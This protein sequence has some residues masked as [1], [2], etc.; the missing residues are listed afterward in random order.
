[1]ERD[2]R[3]HP[4]PEKPYTGLRHI[5][6]VDD[7]DGVRQLIGTAL[8]ERGYRV[9]EAADGKEAAALA[10]LMAVPPDLVLTEFYLPNMSGIEVVCLV[11]SIWPDTKLQVL[12]AFG[13][14][15]PL[16]A[17]NISRPDQWLLKP[18]TLPEL[19]A[20]VERLAGR[21]DPNLSGR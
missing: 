4:L 9:T 13:T 12:Y 15:P 8:H 11:Q 17:Y 3:K 1:M 6:I 2:A 18:F 5:L 20:S 10:L 16:A 14:S 21:P 7:H 19:Y